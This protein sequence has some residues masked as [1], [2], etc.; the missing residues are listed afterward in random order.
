MITVFVQTSWFKATVICYFAQ[1]KRLQLSFTSL[2]NLE[3][4]MNVLHFYHHSLH[5]GTLM[6]KCTN[7]RVF[8]ANL[9]CFSW[10]LFLFMLY[11]ENKRPHRRLILT[12]CVSWQRLCPRWEN[13][14]CEVW[15]ETSD[16]NKPTDDIHIRTEEEWWKKKEFYFSMPLYNRMLVIITIQSRCGTFEWKERLWWPFVSVSQ[17]SSIEDKRDD[18]GS[19]KESPWRKK[20]H[21]NCLNEMN[22]CGWMCAKKGAFFRRFGQIKSGGKKKTL[23][24]FTVQCSTSN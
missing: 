11:I 3:L 23:N 9:I 17:K 5:I 2:K 15:K 10:F 14:C 18:E 24:T 4:L 7:I 16:T 1:I 20:P 13:A 8:R 19:R 22:E 12:F 6:I 21:D